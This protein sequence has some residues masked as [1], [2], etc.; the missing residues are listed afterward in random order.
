[1]RLSI[2]RLVKRFNDRTI[3]DIDRIGIHVKGGN[4]GSGLAR[5]NAV[6]GRG[7][8]VYLY[9]RPKMR[10]ADIP[11]QLKE[12]GRAWAS[13][14]SSSVATKLIAEH[15]GDLV[16]NVPVGVECIDRESRIL[17]ARCNKPFERYLVA[18]GGEGGNSSN[19][20]QGM[21]GEKRSIEL[22]LKLRPNIGL[23]GFPN[24]GKS[25]LMKS[26]APK[27]N[28]KIASY[29]FTTTKPQMCYITFDEQKDTSDEPFSLTIA[30]LPGLIEGASKNRGRGDAFL[31]HLEYSDIIVM[32]VDI[33][34]FQLKV[35]VTEPY[36]SALETV[37]LLNREIENYDLKILQKPT[38]LVLNKIDLPGG[39]K[40]AGDLQELF[41]SGQ[42][43]KSVPQELRPS[44]PVLFDKVIAASAKNSELDSF[45][46]SIREIYECL[47]PLRRTSLFENE[48]KSKGKFLV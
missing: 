48:E 29:P 22:H 10:F 40:K 6:G 42:W 17:L 16:I 46:P 11:K 23:V 27:K 33:M 13:H 36:R 18:Q 7:G 14:G 38:V 21:R 20:Y 9:T 37:A 41:A 24:A 44:N 43:V 1:M 25:T 28:V 12:E 45:K 32:V 2:L 15:A 30:D 4:G 8:S 3:V 34:G 35:D 39:V 19:A 31:K 26:L 5:Y 47:R